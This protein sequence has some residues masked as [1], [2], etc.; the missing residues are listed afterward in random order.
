MPS[1][2]RTMRRTLLLAS[3]MLCVFGS[4]AVLAADAPPDG[5]A[6]AG[7]SGVS[8][9][10]PRGAGTAPTPSGGAVPDQ[11][12]AVIVTG[13]REPHRRARDSLSPIDVV[14][15]A[16]IARTGQTNVTDALAQLLP[17]VTRPAVGIFDGAPTDFISLRGLNPNET[18]VL[19]N[20][21]RRHNTSF[22]YISGFADAATPVDIDLIPPAL[23]DHVE[24]LRDGASAQYGSDAIAGVVNIILKSTD[25]GGTASAESGLTAQGDGFVVQA[26]GE[27]S[28]RLG[29][30][31]FI[32]LSAD[33]RHRD[34]TVRNR[35][36]DRTGAVTTEILGDP[37]STRYDFGLNAGYELRD[38]VTLYSTETYS[39]R[40]TDVNQVYRLP[41]RLPALYPGGFTPHQTTF[42]NDFSASLGAKGDD[43]LGW[44]WDL[45][46]TYGGDFL[47]NNLRN[48]ANIAL[49]DAT[50]STPRSVHLSNLSTTLLTN[51]L[52]VHRAFTVPHWAHPVTIA[53]GIEHR[54]ETFG[55]GAGSPAS[56]LL[57]GSQAQVGLLP[58]D[59]GPHSRVVYSAYLEPSTRITDAWQVS[60]A[61]RFE[62]YTDFGNTYNGKVSTRYDITPR[63]ALRGTVSS[64]TRAPSLANEFYS[65]LAVGPSSASG[66]LAANSAAARLL[67]A[68]PLEPERSTN[69][70]AGV[71][72]EPLRDLHL[73]VDAYQ[74]DIRDRIVS[75]P[76]IAGPS[77]VAAL[78]VQGIALSPELSPD[79]VSAS[80][81]TNAASTRTRGV[82]V[83]LSYRTRF[84]RFGTIDWDASAN[85]NYSRITHVNSLANGLSDLVAQNSAFLTTS[86]PKN[87]VILGG[88][89]HEGRWD[90]LLHELRYGETI[91]QLTYFEGPDA[92]ST[93]DF[94]RF[95]NHPRWLTNLEVGFRPVSRLRVAFG[96]NNLFDTYPSRIPRENGYYGSEPYDSDGSQIGINGG[97]Y[98]GRVGYE[99]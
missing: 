83:T 44:S 90:V 61:G 38:G 59:A 94:R 82:D 29:N 15:G 70:T 97:F 80:F 87:R 78:G 67:G 23:I 95:V 1:S 74:I 6:V 30:N 18:L 79:D 16:E 46:S 21:K 56:Y 43:L 51:D 86:T 99:F 20:G 24:V 71:V 66:T 92:Y 25:H 12:E 40:F 31:G 39:Y 69:I 41:S 81:F 88:R 52:D 9:A 75:G 64:G 7:V 91:D 13:T 76:G 54:F 55:T 26:G 47:D 3:G 5:Q 19:V 73:T 93:T 36:D 50:G 37:E 77:A 53:G 68:A 85:A 32:D 49:Y 42:E 45:G 22:L 14:T 2:V 11:S 10:K 57:G 60:V 96:A 17:S 4:R 27:K 34:H 65:A 72:A 35:D 58:S 62:H 89:W 98:Y 48:T 28:A 84:R 8:Q 63:L 33:Y